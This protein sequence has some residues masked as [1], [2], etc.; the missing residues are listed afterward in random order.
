MPAVKHLLADGEKIDQKDSEG[1]TALAH[2]L[3]NHD[4]QATKRLLALGAD[5]ATPVT[6]ANFPVALVPV[7]DQDIQEI[8]ILRQSGVDY[9]KLSYRGMTALEVAKRAGNKA[10]LEALG[11]DGSTL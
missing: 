2:A 6:Y 10:L 3:Q 7:M 8:R 9:S 4:P 1:L 5:P 11:G